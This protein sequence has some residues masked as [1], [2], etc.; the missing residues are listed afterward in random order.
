MADVR[1]VG[2]KEEF[3]RINPGANPTSQLIDVADHYRQLPFHLRVLVHSLNEC[4]SK[5]D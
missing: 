3:F 5:G 1:R 2:R 4:L